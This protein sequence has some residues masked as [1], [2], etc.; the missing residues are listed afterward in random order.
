MIPAE[1]TGL[2]ARDV[3]AAQDR[4]HAAIAPKEAA[5]LYGLVELAG[6]V[7]DHPEN[8][9]RFLLFTAAGDLPEI[10]RLRGLGA[11]RKT[12]LLLSTRHEEGAL[13]RC[14]GILATAHLNLAK[15]ESRPRLGRTWE[16]VFYLDLEGD[17]AEPRVA[18]ALTQSRTKQR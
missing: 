17:V 5:G 10:A 8:F 2:A 3:A 11:R 4:S 7:A 15:L 13:A 1:D 18:Q 12:S 14:L 9:T 16:V 6:S